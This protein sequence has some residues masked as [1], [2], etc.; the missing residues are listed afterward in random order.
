MATAFHVSLY[1]SFQD[2][3]KFSSLLTS[4]EDWLY[5]EGVDQMKQ[6]YVDKLEELMVC[7][8]SHGAQH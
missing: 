3:E 4:G 1:L 2:C 8:Q 5:D 7:G 6:A